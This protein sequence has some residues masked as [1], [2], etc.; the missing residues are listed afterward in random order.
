MDH[1]KISLRVF[2]TL[3]VLTAFLAGCGAPEDEKTE[4]EG[5]TQAVIVEVPDFK[6][7][8]A[9]RYIEE[10]LDF[11]PRVPG[12]GPHAETKEYLKEKLASFGAETQIQ[13]FSARR[14]DGVP[15]IGYNVI[16]MFNPDA[17][18][19]ILLCAHWDSRYTADEEDPGAEVPGAN[20]GASGVGVLLEIARLVGENSPEIGIDFVFFDLEDQGISKGNNIQS[21][22][23]GAQNWSRNPHRPAFR[24]RMG[25]LLDMVGAEDATFYKEAFSRQYASKWVDKIWTI[26]DQMGYGNYFIDQP[27]GGVTDDHYFVNTIAGIPTL[28]IIHKEQGSQTGFFEHW[29]TTKDDLSA[30][31]KGTLKAVGRVVTKSV[32]VIAHEFAQ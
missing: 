1:R 14:H 26:A 24:F 11:G 27:G 19:R 9:Y 2:Y 13:T 21:W 31:D 15:L 22:G 20:D 6:V 7:D 32:Y 29:H 28:D 17:P 18:D 3:C 30:I 12:S 8:S 25:I 16:G 23:L 5:K 10:Q 4:V